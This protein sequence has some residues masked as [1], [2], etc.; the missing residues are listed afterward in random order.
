MTGTVPYEAWC[1]TCQVSHPPGTRRCLHCGGPVA[2]SREGEAVWTAAAPPTGA[3]PPG[4][5]RASPADDDAA[6]RARPLQVATAVLWILLAIA[7]AVARA[8]AERG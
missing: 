3:A 1:P 2:P 7:A 8:C 4:H 6:R 5:G